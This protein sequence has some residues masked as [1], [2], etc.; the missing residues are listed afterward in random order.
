L[1]YPGNSFQDKKPEKPVEQAELV[2]SR[3]MAIFKY[4]SVEVTPVFCSC[5][6]QKG[7]VPVN[8]Y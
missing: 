2:R 7:Q 8:K 6:T 1:V 3:E 4:F 5:T